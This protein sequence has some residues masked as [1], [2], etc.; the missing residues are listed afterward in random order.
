MLTLLIPFL[1]AH[2]I[3]DFLL[4]PDKWVQARLTHKQHTK[5]LSYHIGVHG[6]V[7][8]IALQFQFR[9]WLGILTVLVTHY[10]IDRCKAIYQNKKNTISLF[11]LD[12]LAHLLVI[13]LVVYQYEPYYFKAEPLLVSKMLLLLMAFIM[14]T[15][16]AAVVIKI[17]LSKWKMKEQNPNQA[18]KFIGMLERLF[19]FLFI[20]MNYWEGVGFLLGAKSIFRFGD[21]NN[22]NDR[23]LTE[24]VL[25]GTLLS[26]GLAI[27]ISLTYQFINQLL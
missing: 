21:L 15:Q 27:S 23:N 25:V 8:L 10:I 22:A 26:F 5:Y 16:V 18:G 13:V 3:G 20:T 2:I 17:L 24:Y 7:L 9:Y 14:Q 11:F 12:Q 19:I 4:Q 1:L 6:V